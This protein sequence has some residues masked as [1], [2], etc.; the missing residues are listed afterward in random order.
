MANTVKTTNRTIEVAVKDT[1]Y[2]MPTKLNVQSVVLIPGTIQKGDNYV[3]IIENNS[4]S[5]VKILLTSTI[6]QTESRFW[7]FNQRLQLGFIYLNGVFDIGAKVIFNIGEIHCG[8]DA[9]TPEM[10]MKLSQET[11]IL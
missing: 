1:D 9:W 2:M 3:Y 7:I 10:K 6:T 8:N 4:D 5:S 11:A